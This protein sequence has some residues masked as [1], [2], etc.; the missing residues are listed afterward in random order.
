M[1]PSDPSPEA[2]DAGSVDTG[3]V[4]TGY[5]DTG[6]VDTGY[7]D[8]GYVA[9]LAAIAAE[10]GI[11]RIGVA[12]AT[13][14]ERARTALLERR[15][16]GLHDT[17]QF[18]YKNPERSTDP[19]AAVRGAR[20]VLVG[21]R[22]YLLDEPMVEMGDGSSRSPLARIAR[23]AQADHYEPLR[24]GLRAVARQLRRDGFKAVAFADDNSIVDREIAYRA[25]LGWFGK[26]ANLLLS[27]AGSWVVLGSV[28][29]TAPLPVVA[30]PA[31][32]G[33][34]ACRRCIDA[35]PTGAIVQPGMVDAGKCLAWVLQKPG[36][37]DPVFRRAIGDR[38]Y[39]CDDCQE[40]CPPTVRLGPTQALPVAQ[41][42]TVDTHLDVCELLDASDADVLDRW[43]RWYLADRDPR[44]LRRNALVVL[45]NSGRGDDA[46][47]VATLARYVGS[48]DPAL[49]LHALWAARE[50]G[51]T[52]LVR[53]DLGL[54]ELVPDELVP[55]DVSEGQ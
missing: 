14:M 37:I 52:E 36:I 51:L 15:A 22:P 55:D 3:Y 4:D 28:V 41:A 17:M 18:T 29:T 25:G 44:W 34:G 40:V 13:V 16:S 50:L 39:G 19:Q 5:V 20:A 32:D 7:V 26:N 9:S 30:E 33:C 10:F 24:E 38:I 53:D 6:Y 54:T 35:C 43:G 45:G 48:D 46:R 49:R 27:G 21:A 8:A 23:Y 31:A 2:L 11:T 42:G 47:V 12:P 1:R